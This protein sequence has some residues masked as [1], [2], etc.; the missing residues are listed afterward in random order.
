MA[1]KN[2]IP[3]IWSAAIIQ[4]RNKVQVARMICN[5]D[6]EGEV[7]A[8]GDKVI[9]PGLVDPTI[10]TYSG[11]VTYEDL[12]DA[13][14]TLYLD[15]KKYFAVSIDDVDAVQAKGALLQKQVKRGAAKLGET[16]D[17][18]VLGLYGQA[19]LEVEDTTCDTTT[20]LSDISEAAR[21]L[22][23]QDVPASGRWMVVS[24]WVKEKLEL[25]GIVFSI[26]EGAEAMSG[27]EWARVRGFDLY[28]STSVTNY[29]ASTS[30][31][32][33]C[34]AGGEDSIVYYDQLIK[35][36]A[37]ER[38]GSFSDGVK[39]LHV[40]GAKVVRPNELVS[41]ALTYAAETAI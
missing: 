19:N 38:E 12:D 17:A 36:K 18:Y 32:T 31:V 16:A 34:L 26:K 2:F 10:S 40:Y 4:E 35:T 25:A 39:S 15:Q 33:Y 20:I 5:T 21:K 8:A 23:E 37:E 27:K 14:V 1:V 29:A 6:G 13:S 3:T 41:L 24:P 7:S 28:V 22:D 9:F 30:A 11:T